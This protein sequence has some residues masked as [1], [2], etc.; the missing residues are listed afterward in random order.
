MSAQVSRA[1]PSPVKPGLA[2]VPGQG[3]LSG[4]GPSNHSLA[5]ERESPRELTGLIEP[6]G[7]CEGA[8]AKF[9]AHIADDP[10]VASAP[11]PRRTN[12]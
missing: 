2:Q 11:C 10:I 6:V 3:F 7:E 4:I 8:I 12:C 1:D 5:Y 9:A